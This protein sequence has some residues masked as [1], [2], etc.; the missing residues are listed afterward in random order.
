MQF[1]I[2][3]RTSKCYCSHRIGYSCPG[4]YDGISHRLLSKVLPIS[5]LVQVWSLV[6]NVRSLHWIT[7]WNRG[8][9]IDIP[10]NIINKLIRTS[11]NYFY[12]ISS[13]A[14]VYHVWPYFTY[15]VCLAWFYLESWLLNA[16]WRDY[17]FTNFWWIAYIYWISYVAEVCFAVQA[18][19]WLSILPN[20]TAD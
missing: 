13:F 18:A 10:H 12:Q 9:Y 16:S 17:V 5:P 14:Y 8:S 4:I 2:L 6:D 19:Y 20:G 11:S 7:M 1:E 15:I 3:L